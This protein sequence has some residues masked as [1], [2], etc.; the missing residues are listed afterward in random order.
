VAI[1]VSVRNWHKCG[2]ENTGW[3]GSDVEIIGF[4]FG[5]V[6]A[7]L[8]MSCK[9]CSSKKLLNLRTR[10]RMAFNCIKRIWLFFILAIG[11][12][13]N[14]ATAQ[15][16]P[17]AE[18][19]A[20]QIIQQAVDK[21]H[22]APGIVIGF[23]D[24]QRSWVVAYGNCRASEN[25]PVNGDTLFEIGSITKVFT[26]LLLQDMADHSELNLDD[27]IGKFLPENVR[28]PSRN[29]KQ[30]SLVDLA[31]HYSGL[32]RMPSNMSWWYFLWNFMNIFAKYDSDKLYKF[33]SEYKLPRDIGTQYEYS[34]L[35]IGLLGHILSL[36][37]GMDYE[38]LVVDR[39][40][41][42]LK[43][44]STR[45]V[46]SPELNARL[47]AG[48]RS[49]GIRVHNYDF[50]VLAGCGALRS[51][52]NDLLK[53]LSA[54][55]GLT[56]TPLY[57]AM[58]K[59]QVPRRDKIPGTKIGLVW[60]I[61]SSGIISH[62]GATGGYRSY[63]AFNPQK[64]CGIVALA[65]SNKDSFVSLA[66]L[67]LKPIIYKPMSVNAEP[68][69]FSID[70]RQYRFNTMIPL[71]WK[72]AKKQCE[73]NKGWDLAVLRNQSQLDQIFQMIKSN[74][75]C[76]AWIGAR[77]VGK[78]GIWSWVTGEPFSFAPWLPGQPDNK[79]R[80]VAAEITTT[81][82]EDNAK[83]GMNNL[84]DEALPYL[85]E[86]PAAQPSDLNDRKK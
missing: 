24:E 41:A 73:L 61:G 46:L 19:A 51:S 60:E 82:W 29:G 62:S 34:N 8:S 50:Q 25:K 7:L 9:Y 59:T 2:V 69:N 14:L 18:S 23:V 81:W 56:A 48:H 16:G 80:E 79:G 28:I 44:D 37:S 75:G 26:A 84:R 57:T 4:K 39:I 43:M 5:A 49:L 6:F 35:G 21:D 76:G 40:C 31:T 74:I 68:V 11:L 86:G 27:P 32:P 63:I 42:P 17:L 1:K 85:C 20:M 70:G 71:K 54:N 77:D 83:F 3:I 47:A 33:L 53:F 58:Q 52:A 64:R 55:M 67:L 66:S 38:S 45:I 22:I 78:N 12:N 72:E 13:N 30:I 65:N 15:L 36:R 10:F